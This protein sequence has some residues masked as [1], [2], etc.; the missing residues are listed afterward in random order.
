MKRIWKTIGAVILVCSMCLGMTKT[1]YAGTDTAWTKVN[2]KYVN[3]KGEE[4][5]NAI[6]RG[7]DVSK[8][9]GEIDWEKVKEDDV[10]FAIIRCG[11]GQDME[12]QDDPYWKRNADACTEL[13]IPFGVYIYSY[14]TTVEGAIGEANHVLRLVN[15]YK[16]SYPIFYDLEND[17]QKALSTEQLGAMA[18]AFCDTIEGAGYKAGIYANKSWWTNYLTDSVFESWDRWVAQYASACTYSGNY[19]IWQCTKTGSINGISGNVDIDFLIGDRNTVT[20]GSKGDV[21]QDGYIDIFDIQYIQ[22]Y[23][24]EIRQLNEAES[25]AADANGDGSVDIFDIQTIQKHILEIA[26][27][28]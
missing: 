4:I 26:L 27:I 1:A 15:D 9:Q 10:S 20:P 7:I 12:S 22:Q 2:G 18:K 6:A 16:L 8:Y 14:A 25:N 17:S 24:L 3:D 5:P 21:T 28:S 19:K 13:N 11:Y 23:I